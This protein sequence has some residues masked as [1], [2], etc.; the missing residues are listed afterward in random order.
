MVYVRLT[1]E[2]NGDICMESPYNPVFIENLKSA[3]PYSG[4]K[5]EPALARWLISSLYEM[6][7]QKFFGM[8]GILMAEPI[9]VHDERESSKNATP[10]TS[11]PVVIPD[12]PDDLREAFTL[13]HLAPTAPLGLAEISYKWLAR[14]YHPDM[15]TGDDTLIRR[16]ND[17]IAI[18]RSYL[19]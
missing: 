13:L 9:H 18:I 6:E 2:P 19:T 11:T 7:L 3:I 4:R 15:S 16:I 5:W 12:M 1:A 10:T 17:A 14:I 8:H